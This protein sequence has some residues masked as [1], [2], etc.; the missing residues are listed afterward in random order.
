MILKSLATK[1]AV[2]FLKIS[3]KVKISQTR[4]KDAGLR[5]KMQQLNK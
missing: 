2:S 1:I 4:Q 3:F 5:I